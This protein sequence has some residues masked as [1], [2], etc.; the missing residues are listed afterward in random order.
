MFAR[1][2]TEPGLP[3]SL[4]ARAPLTSTRT[5]ISESPSNRGP[6]GSKGEDR[7][8]MHRPRCA[9][10]IPQVR[11]IAARAL[12]RDGRFLHWRRALHSGRWTSSSSCSVSQ[13]WPP[14]TSGLPPKSITGLL[15]G[16]SGSV[17]RTTSAMDVIPQTRIHLG[18]STPPIWEDRASTSRPLALA[19]TSRI[20]STVVVPRMTTG[21]RAVTSG[22]SR[23]T[24]ITAVLEWQR[25]CQPKPERA[26]DQV[27]PG[28]VGAARIQRTVGQ[29]T[30][31]FA[32]IP[33]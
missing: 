23:V 24:R 3:T 33:M 20:C 17:T 2:V 11:P 16:E 15:G 25:R 19:A 12:T 26:T 22:M 13:A 1:K 8:C 31:Q 30:R 18:R 32:L 29:I 5:R 28:W 27:L 21:N 7:P 10:A 14:R 9:G 6:E 4:W